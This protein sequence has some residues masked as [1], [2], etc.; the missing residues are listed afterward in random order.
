MILSW[1]GIP[2]A[3]CINN[4]VTA[5]ECS[6]VYISMLNFVKVFKRLDQEAIPLFCDEGISRIIC[7]N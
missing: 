6:T 7:D 1:S 2:V 3:I 4:L 5:T